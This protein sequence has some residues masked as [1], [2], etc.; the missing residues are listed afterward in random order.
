MLFLQRR[1]CAQKPKRRRSVLTL[2]P[3]EPRDVPAGNLTITNALL[4]DANNNPLSAPS[5]ASRS[6][7]GRSGKRPA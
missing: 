2:E 7:S 6:S 5:S 3:L 4:V 1:R